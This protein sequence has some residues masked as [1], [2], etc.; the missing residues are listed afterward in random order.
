MGSQ[1]YA[2]E[3][4]AGVG[5]GIDNLL[6]CNEFDPL[7]MDELRKIRERAQA[8]LKEMRAGIQK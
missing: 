3:A 6:S 5:E 2:H 1:K 8:N 4:A 7:V